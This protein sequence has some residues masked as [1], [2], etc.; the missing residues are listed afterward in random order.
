[1]TIPSASLPITNATVFDILKPKVQEN[2]RIFD[3]GAGRG[4]MCERLGEFAKDKG[5]QPRNCLVAGEVVPEIFEYRDTDCVKL[6]IHSE[7]PFPDNEFTAVYAIEVLE[8]TRRPYDFFDEA[9]RVLK[10]D[11]LLVF[12]VPNLMHLHSRLKFFFQ[13]YGDLFGPPSSLKKNAGRTCGHIMPLNYACFHYGLTVS[14]FESIR[15]HI[16]RRKKSALSLS[17]ILHPWLW[18]ATRLRDL[19]LRKFDEE[20]WMENRKLIFKMNSMDMLTS[21]SC[22][23]SAT[24]PDR[25]AGDSN[26][27]NV[28]A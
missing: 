1:M 10:P 14:G 2:C 26:P 22:I 17:L 20:V 8:H 7:I 13:G 27:A 11:G 4:H 5:L 6:G 28:A 23:V 9:F 16:D 15:T 3:F 18:L 19:E 12:S 25:R 24:K 21:R